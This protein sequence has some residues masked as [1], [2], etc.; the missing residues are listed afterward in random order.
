[1]TKHKRLKSLQIYII[2]V[3]GSESIML[4][5]QYDALGLPK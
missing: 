2:S 5:K 3:E 4:L 1:M